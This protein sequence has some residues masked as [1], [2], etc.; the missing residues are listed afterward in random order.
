MKVLNIVIFL[1]KKQ[2]RDRLVLGILDK[3]LSEK[4][5]LKFNLTLEKAIEITRQSD[6]VKSQ[7]K[8]QSVSHAHV[9]LAQKSGA[10]GRG[11]GQ[12]QRGTGNRGRGRGRGQNKSRDGYAQHNAG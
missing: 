4:L 11:Q 7:I 9:E 12:P 2:I 1:I 10:R 5:Q 8:N 6:M 3:E